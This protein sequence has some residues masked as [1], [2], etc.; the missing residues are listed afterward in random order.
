MGELRQEIIS[1]LNR[2]Q[3]GLQHKKLLQSFHALFE[4]TSNSR[5]FFETFFVIFSNTLLVFKREPAAERLVDFVAKFAFSC[6]SQKKEE[7]D[8]SSSEDEEDNFTQLLVAKLT[9]IHEA[10][11]K[12]VRFRVCQLM[13]KL[14]ATVADDETRHLPLSTLNRI[15]DAMSVR[16]H[17][18]VPVTRAQAV[19]VLARV[20][21]PVQPDSPIINTLLWTMESDPS[22]DVR[23]AAV[24]NI[25]I[26]ST[27]LPVLIGRTRDINK[28]VRRATFLTLS[29]KCSIKYFSIKQRL[30]LLQCGLKDRCPATK[31]ACVR[32][33]L[34]SWC[35]EC[36]GDFLQLLYRLDVESSPDLSEIALM[37][38]FDQ[39]TDEELLSSMEKAMSSGNNSEEVNSHTHV[40]MIYL[41][42]L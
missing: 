29:E 42:L 22:P 25:A 39:L 37:S 17:D 35:M 41:N 36:E 14:T 19:Q 27:T 24:T 30:Q 34:R 12:A 15:V 33:L 1:L 18:K 38:L 11:E 20:Y 4:K 32:G 16:I 2:V 5:V 21:D 10:R 13:A 9:S 31:E 28:S 7:E 26:T 8:S 40:L 6:L 23:R 3:D